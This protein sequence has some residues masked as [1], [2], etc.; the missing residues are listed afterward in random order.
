MTLRIVEGSIASWVGA[1]LVAAQGRE[2]RHRYGV[3]EDRPGSIDDL[4]PDQLVP[5]DGVFLIGWAGDEAVACGGVRRHTDGVGEIKRMYVVPEHRRH[6]YARVLL[7]ALE[8]RAAALGYTRLVLE[9]GRPQPEA[10]A[11]YEAEGYEPIP[12]YGFHRD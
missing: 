12:P 4:A 7:R 8:E 9:T 5:P 11:L 1:A 10:I 3:P 6:G 2:L